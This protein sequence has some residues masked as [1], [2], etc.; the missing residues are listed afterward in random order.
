MPRQPVLPPPPRSTIPTKLHR[1]PTRCFQ[2]PFWRHESFPSICI[3]AI[4]LITTNRLIIIQLMIT[5][6]VFLASL[7]FLYCFFFLW[8]AFRQIEFAAHFLMAVKLG[9][10]YKD[11]IQRNPTQQ[12]KTTNKREQL[13]KEV[14]PETGSDINVVGMRKGI[15]ADGKAVET[16]GGG[17]VLGKFRGFGF[18]FG[19]SQESLT[20]IQVSPVSRVIRAKRSLSRIFSSF[21]RQRHRPAETS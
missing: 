7:L 14:T 5:V 10:A 13:N 12:H 17:G 3:C 6:S 11:E 21:I 18:V 1:C 19:V 15:W 20:K 4:N 8:V 9:W 16:L 2:F